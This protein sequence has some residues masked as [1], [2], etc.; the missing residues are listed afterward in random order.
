MQSTIILGSPPLSGSSLFLE[1][2]GRNLFSANVMNLGI[3][4]RIWIRFGANGCDD[5]EEYSDH[6]ELL[7]SCGK[8][9]SLDGE[10]QGL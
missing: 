4:P 1:D 5:V 2:L 6:T 8:G 10:D 3:S 7:K 9:V